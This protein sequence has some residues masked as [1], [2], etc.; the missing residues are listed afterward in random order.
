MAAPAPLEKGKTIMATMKSAKT[1]LLGAWIL[2]ALSLGAC[3][4][5]EAGD[6]GSQASNTE[7][8]TTVAADDNAV[9]PAL[10]AKVKSALPDIRGA[11]F[12]FGNGNQEP[13]VLTDEQRKKA[14]D[15]VADKNLSSGRDCGCGGADFFIMFYT[16]SRKDLFTPD[17]EVAIIRVNHDSYLNRW[18]AAFSLRH[19]SGSETKIGLIALNQK[20][21]DLIKELSRGTEIP[22]DSPGA[23]TP[24]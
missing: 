20:F 8:P 12:N 6:T 1:V 10:L 3:T 14:I 4:A 11:E 24:K 9:A 5:T 7:V 23:T 16:W 2:G 17:N 19:G 13:I 21:V 18:T 22:I 15:S